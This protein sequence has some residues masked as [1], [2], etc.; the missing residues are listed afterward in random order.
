[1]RLDSFVCFSFDWM[2]F[3]ITES[4]MG[5]IEGNALLE[6]KRRARRIAVDFESICLQRFLL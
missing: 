5:V 3:F 2:L 4:V 6:K 1:M